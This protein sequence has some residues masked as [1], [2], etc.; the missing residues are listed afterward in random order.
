MHRP[1]AFLS[2][3]KPLEEL[4]ESG[5]KQPASRGQSLKWPIERSHID[6]CKVIVFDFAMT[7]SKNKKTKSTYWINTPS[8]RL[9]A[10]STKAIASGKPR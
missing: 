8:P 9:S 6:S 5:E 4:K 10:S 1:L 7:K 3:S 2:G